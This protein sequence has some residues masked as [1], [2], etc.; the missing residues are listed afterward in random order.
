MFFQLNAHR[1]WALLAVWLSC[2]EAGA[3]VVISSTRV[4][5]PA[6]QTEITVKLS[7]EGRNPSLVQAWIDDGPAQL[8]AQTLQAPFSLVPSLFRLDP[9]K[10]QSLRLFHTGE[11]MPEDRESLYWLNVLDV[12]PKGTGNS[13]QVSLRSR[14]KLFY[15]PAKLPGNVAQAHQTL[16]WR[17]LRHGADGVLQADNPS[18]YFV[19]LAK[20]QVHQANQVLDLEP[21][22]IAPFSSTRFDAP[23]LKVGGGIEVRYAYIDDYGAVHERPEAV[24]LERMN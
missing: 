12:P 24:S 6:D 21:G 17:V 2:S 3:S 15:R 16:R 8:D 14:I 19:N 18:P 9:G 4:V 20:V 10:G 13:L 1:R 7:N 5:Y 23:G 11:T 22:H